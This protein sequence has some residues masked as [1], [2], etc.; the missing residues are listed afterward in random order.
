MKI[1]TF[2]HDA[3]ATHKTLALANAMATPAPAP[4]NRVVTAINKYGTPA[5]AIGGAAA[6]AVAHTKSKRDPQRKPIAL[7]GT[8]G[9]AAAL[10]SFVTRKYG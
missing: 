4:S 8:V 9:L 10:V 6:L 7:G 3:D 2:G 1:F 5:L